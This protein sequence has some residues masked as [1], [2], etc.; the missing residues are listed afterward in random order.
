MNS[1]DFFRTI[2]NSYISPVLDVLI[3][4]FILYK[5][6]EMIV[7]TNTVQ[8]FKSVLIVAMAFFVVSIFQLKTLMWI[9]KVMLPVLA[10]AFAIVFQPEIRKIMLKLGQTEWLTFGAKSKH[11]SVD[12]VIQ[13]AERLSELR[14]GMLVVFLRT[15]KHDNI[16]NTGV[17][18]NADVS[19]SLLLTIFDHDTPLHDAACFVQNGKIIAA[20]C[21]LP[22][23][24]QYN[25]KKTFGTR[26]RAAL[27]MSEQG[28]C[29]VMVVSEET[30]AISLAYEGELHYRLS[31]AELTRKLEE[32]LDTSKEIKRKDT[33]DEYKV[34]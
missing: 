28:D 3:L 6:Y 7:K 33:L 25:I 5:A 22:L 14:R 27:G 18:L 12:A 9:F 10:L 17:M 29:V 1:L 8:L 26:H 31:V 19:A 13:A 2:Y 15:T 21:F 11:T 24:E 30:G 16:I 4:A 34:S 23:S 20:G 32:L